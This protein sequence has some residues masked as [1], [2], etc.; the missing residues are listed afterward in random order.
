[1]PIMLGVMID[2][3]VYRQDIDLFLRI[4][5]IFVVMSL[6]SCALYFLIYTQYQHLMSTYVYDIQSDV[7]SHLQKANAD[8]MSS[9]KTGDIISIAQHYSRECMYFITRNVIHTINPIIN[10]IIL[11]IYIFIISPWIGF[12]TLAAVP[13][14]VVVS[15]R[16]GK[17]IRNYSNEHKMYY[18]NYISYVFEIFT[19][20]RD[21]RLLGA[22]KKVNMEVKKHHKEIFKIRNRTGVSAITAQNIISGTNLLAQLAIFTILAYLVSQGGMSVGLLTVV[23]AFFASLTREV[24]RLSHNY[25]DSQNRIGYIQRIFDLMNSPTEEEWPGKNVLNVSGGEIIIKDV[26]FS[27]QNGSHVLHDFNLHIYSGERIALCGKSGCGKT[28]FGYMLLGFYQKK[29]GSITIDGQ[30]IYNCSLGSIRDNIGMISQDVLLFDGSI[31]ENLVLGKPGADDEEVISSLQ[32]AGIWSFVSGL[33]EGIDTV[34]GA[35]G[36]GLS[37][38]QKQRIAIA[39]IYLK[40]PRIIIFDEATSSLDAENEEQIHQAW[41]VMLAGRTSIIIAHRQS[42]VMLCDRAA[43][44]ENGGITELGDPKELERSSQA[45]RNLFALQEVSADAKKVEI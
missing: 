30:D 26:A 29:K 12:F 18:G 25:L 21:I 32:K 10:I 33:P 3:I 15:A 4:S 7:F 11:N 8:F 5:L 23:L 45:F 24:D 44:M 36:V 13:V 42:S 27:Y 28:T 14:S 1:M 43:M 34:V 38:G 31:K 35:K 22:A 19:G 16:F 9:A 6:F 2:Q 40:N 41:E 37:G 20:I 17:K 39:R